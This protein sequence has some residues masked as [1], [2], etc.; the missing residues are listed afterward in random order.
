MAWLNENWGTIL[1]LA[2]LGVAVFFII[3]K[4]RK[5]VKCGSGLC[6]CGCRECAMRGTCHQKNMTKSS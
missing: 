4:L 1:V 2:I 6:G 5:D 3:R